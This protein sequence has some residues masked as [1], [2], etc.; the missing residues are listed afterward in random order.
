M[1]TTAVDEF[2]WDEWNVDWAKDLSKN[3]MWAKVRSG[4]N[5]SS[6]GEPLF[7]YPETARST[8]DS[9]EVVKKP[10]ATKKTEE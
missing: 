5:D 2:D 1:T 3:E 10:R 8:T 7:R 4:D 6:S 9:E